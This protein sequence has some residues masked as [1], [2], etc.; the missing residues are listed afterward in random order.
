[1]KKNF[2]L[3]FLV[4]ATIVACSSNDDTPTVVSNSADGLPLTAGSV[5]FSKYVSLGNSL[6]SG[7]SDGALFKAGQDNS[8]PS[9]LAQQF[10][11][12]GGGTFTI[13]YMN[14]N[15]GGFT[16]G[17]TVFSGPRMYYTGSASSP[18]STVTGPPTTE[19]TT[20]LTG[21][22]NN[23]GVPGAKSFH[24]L[25]PGYGSLAGLMNNTA[26]PY[27]VRFASSST[28]SV[29]GDAMAQH[30]T[31]FSLWIGNND[32]LGYA[33]SGGDGTNP[34]TPPTGVAGVG[35]D[36][37]Y[38][39]LVNTLTSEN[40]KGVV[41]NIPYVNTIPFFTTVPFNP[42]SASVLG[43]GNAA[44]GQATINTLNTQLYGPLKQALTAFG[45]GNRINLLSTTASNPLLI[46][47]ESLTDLTAQLT[48][49]F[50]PSLGATTAAL[51]GQIFG[52]ARQTTNADLVLLTT[53]SAIGVAP[54]SSD[55]GLGMAP[56]YPLNKF[57]ITFPL[58][59]KHILIPTEI[60]ELKAVTDAYNAT[61]LAAANSKGLAFVD[62]NGT[63]SQLFN[64]GIVENNFTLLSTYVTGGAFSLDGVHPS[65][66]GYALIANKFLEAINLKYGSNIKGVDLGNYRILYPMNS[67]SF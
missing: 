38:T 65:P 3:L 11:L 44:T 50:T 28:A 34:I 21:P 19:I 40:A 62:A 63:M 32:V 9:I 52:K 61:I 20:H 10:A 29:I 47:D 13:P 43:G 46:K 54:T 14:D 39:A 53:Q 49:A 31:F 59:D 17:G 4:A 26:N 55:S 27:F 16:I 41:A 64:G 25:A 18:V 60:A 66:R 7:Y 33:T 2:K 51:Y 23:M 12:V 36:G 67:N 48:A 58:Q 42:L 15:I 8:Y 1:M 37:T 5:D 6:C 45:A 35:F 57:G 30:P 56:P 24:L 22:F